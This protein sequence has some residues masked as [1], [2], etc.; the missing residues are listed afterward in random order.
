LPSKKQ[1]IEQIYN[2]ILDLLYSD[3][4]K[5]KVFDKR[6][7]LGGNNQLEWLILA[8][9][10]IN[11][12]K[13]RPVHSRKITHSSLELYAHD[14]HTTLISQPS[15]LYSFTMYNHIE[16]EDKVYKALEYVYMMLKT[17]FITSV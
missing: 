14:K 13:V 2:Q 5:E 3:A 11:I 16:D 12:I 4:F 1:L 10:D 6:L 15:I 8:Q 9:D 17:I 7:K